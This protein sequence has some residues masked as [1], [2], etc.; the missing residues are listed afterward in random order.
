MSFTTKEIVKKHI[1]DH[2]LGSTAIVN[3]PLQMQASGPSQFGRRMILPDSETVKAKEQNE[4]VQEHIS[5]AGGDTSPLSHRLLIPDSVVVASDSSLG[6]V[7]V[8]NVDYQ[9]ECGLGSLRRIATGSIPAAADVIVWYLHYRA[10]QKGS[11]YTIDYQRGTLSRRLSGAIEAGQWV[12]VDCITEYGSLDDEAID[13]AISEA[14]E[15]VLS[16]IDE[17][18]RQS[19]DRALVMAETYLAVAIIC[20]IRAMESISP[21]RNKGSGNDALSWSALSDMYR[22]EAYNTMSRFAGAIGIFKSP[23]KA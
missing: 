4:P 21:S 10:Y 19:S 16:F 2:H 12:L 1:L 8:E 14:D 5:F 13:N 6:H 11:D 20:R 22:K 23:S 17:A 18:H 7:Y 3:E 9:V 15:L